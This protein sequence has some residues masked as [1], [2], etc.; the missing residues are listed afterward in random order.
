MDAKPKIKVYKSG[1]LKSGIIE[2]IL[3]I[4]IIVLAIL[5]AILYTL[6]NPSYFALVII[7]AG[8]F[9]GI[10]IFLLYLGI[11]DIYNGS[12]FKTLR[13]FGVKDVAKLLY[14]DRVSGLK[15]SYI[16][17]YQYRCQGKDFIMEEQIDPMLYDHYTVGKN[18]PVLVY[19]NRAI[20]DYEKI[21][22]KKYY[23]KN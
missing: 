19:D 9:L 18:I 23:E 7:F 14:K 17:R 2:L 1:S 5:F 12:Y 6:G 4:T 11:K 10:G 8:L 3:S 16:Y 13:K 20:I 15:K 21:F 22:G